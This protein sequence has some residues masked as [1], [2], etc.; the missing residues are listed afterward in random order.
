MKNT[1]FCKPINE[2]KT[3]EFAPVTLPP[4]PGVPTESEYN[5]AGWFRNEIQAPIIP[6]GKVV[7]SSFYF[8]QDNVVQASYEYEDAPKQMRVFSKLY[9][10][11]AL[12]QEGL[13]DKV[14]AFI[15]AQVITNK[16]GQT[17]PLRRLYNTANDFRDT[18]P[19]FSQFLD[20]IKTTL[21]VDDETVERILKA[22][23]VNS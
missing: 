21:G 2:G 4:N 5:A 10:E 9:L 12:F 20:A 11:Q 6:Y 22:S 1:K 18:N 14:D 19:Y 7:K 3:I 13:L 15:D 8:I 17:M 23:E 16:Q